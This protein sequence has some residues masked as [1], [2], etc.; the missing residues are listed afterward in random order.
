MRNNAILAALTVVGSAVSWWP[1]CVEP[2]FYLPLWISVACAAL[3]TGLSTIL[4]PKMWLLFFYASG[5]GTFGGLYFSLII[6]PPSGPIITSWIPL[7]VVIAL[8][9]MFAALCA[10]LMMWKRSISNKPLR[11]AIWI[12]LIACVAFGPVT[13]AMA[14]IFRSMSGKT[15]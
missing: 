7:L 8:V 3:C 5:L 12:A 13:V 10:R 4:A 9:V 6:W 2:T 11:R 1:V 15:Y 14:A